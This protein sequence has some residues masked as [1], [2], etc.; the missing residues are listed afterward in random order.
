[1]S[2]RYFVAENDSRA[3]PYA[4]PYDGREVMLCSGLISP[5]TPIGWGFHDHPD[6]HST[7]IRTLIPR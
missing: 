4:V 2:K 6:T 5:D 3:A 7:N 1:M